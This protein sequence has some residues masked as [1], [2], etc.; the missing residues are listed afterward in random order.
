MNVGIVG[1]GTIG[2]F[3]YKRILALG[4]KVSFV[5]RSAGVYKTP[6]EKILF[7]KNITRPLLVDIDIVFLV[8]PT[9]DD[10]TKA[11]EYIKYFLDRKIAVVTCEKG[12]LSNYF[13]E[14]EP[15]L[16][17]VG[18]SATV[19]GGTRLLHSVRDWCKDKKDIE[20]HA[21]INGTL[22]YIFD[23][24]SSDKTIEE[25]TSEVLLKGFAEPG[26]SN[27][28]DIIRKETTGDVSMKTAILFNVAGISD[29]KIRANDIKI[30]SQDNEVSEKIIKNTKKYR[31]MVSISRE[32]SHKHILGFT[33]VIDGWVLSG[34][35]VTIDDNP[36][37]KKLSLP[38]VHNGVLVQADNKEYFVSG[39]GAGAEPTT[40]AMIKDAEELIINGL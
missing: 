23:A 32:K 38:G 17:H 10:G 12:A 2:S 30:A 14:L 7:S 24:L 27:F 20:I 25:V 29:V 22:N 9:L 16:D 36:I 21:V 15:R 33:H 26:S 13:S 1:A 6:N 35:F 8:I 18:Y 34:G 3:L 39:E 5:A 37:F 4:W 40:S 19:G 28:Y 31:Y 11:Y